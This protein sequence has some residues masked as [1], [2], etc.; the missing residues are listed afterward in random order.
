MMKKI[1]LITLAI[2]VFIWADFSNQDMKTPYT[3]QD[4]TS[5]VSTGFDNELLPLEQKLIV[6]EE[7]VLEDVKHQNPVQNE[8]PDKPKEDKKAK[9]SKEL[10]HKYIPV[11][12]SPRITEV[13]K[14][15]KEES[16]VEKIRKELNIQGPSAKELKIKKMREDLNIKDPSGKE[17]KIDRIRDELNIDYRVPKYESSLDKRMNDVKEDLG[18]EDGLDMDSAIS[19]IKQTLRLEDKPKKDEGFSFTNSLSTF[20]DTIGMDL[21]VPSFFGTTKK[22]KESG[23]LDSVLSFG[24]LGDIKDT[25]TSLYKGAKYSGQSAEMMSG[26][27]YNSSKMYNTMFGVFDDSPFNIFEEEE[28]ASLFD[29]I[30][31][32]NTVMDMFN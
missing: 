31:H 1:L 18:L 7:D 28:E 27:M 13:K 9:K 11:N 30:E 32:G 4:D 2:S 21:G 5:E 25:G 22:K 20:G 12:K 26:M 24:I 29:V 16:E 19:S 6:P 3:I 15:T 14:M 23:V 10:E 8:I 17:K